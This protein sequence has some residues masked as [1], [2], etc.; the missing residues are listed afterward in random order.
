MRV[1]SFDADTGKII[2]QPAEG[3]AWLAATEIASSV[4]PGMSPD[5]VNAAYDRH[6]DDEGAVTG[7][8]PRA[9]V[10]FVGADLGV[11]RIVRTTSSEGV[12]H[13]VLVLWPGS[14]GSSWHSPAEIQ[15]VRGQ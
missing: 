3:I 13:S 14:T 7:Y 1:I 11:G 4:L 12:M 10:T 8:E 15:P 2:D 5:D 6:M 9:A